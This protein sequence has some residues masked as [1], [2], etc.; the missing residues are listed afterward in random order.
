MILEIR[1]PEY[2]IG[3]VRQMRMNLTIP[4]KLLWIE[5]K[6]KKWQAIGLDFSIQYIDTFLIFTVTRKNLQ[7]KLME[8]FINYERIMMSIGINSLIAL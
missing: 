2:I 4:E 1:L 5:L 3:L 7:Y 8:K 6:T